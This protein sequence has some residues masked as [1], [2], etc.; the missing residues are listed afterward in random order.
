MNEAE[1]QLNRKSSE[2]RCW[3]NQQ[4]GEVHFFRQYEVMP[5][6]TKYFWRLSSEFFKCF[7]DII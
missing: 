4:S 5:Q 1:K 7:A 6:I 2:V 3:A